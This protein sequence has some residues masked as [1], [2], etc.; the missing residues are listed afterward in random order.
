AETHAAIRVSDLPVIDAVPGQIRQ[1]FQNLISNALKFSKPGEK[2]VIEVSG[3]L[4]GHKSIDAPAD[5]AGEY[6]RIVVKDNGIGFDEKF[7]D[8][9]FIIFQRLH[10]REKYEGTGIGL[11]ITKKII[12]KHGGLI[13]ANSK[14]NHGSSF[15]LI[16]PVKQV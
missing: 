5:E 8:R 11:A 10:P 13:T 9:I 16:L 1:V 6:M 4:I 14:E 7:L 12:D 2:P 15:I 3:A